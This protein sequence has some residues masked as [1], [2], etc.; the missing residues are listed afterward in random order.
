MVLHGG[1][2]ALREFSSDDW[3]ARHHWT[4]RAEVCRFQPWGPSLDIAVLKPAISVTG[5]QALAAVFNDARR[6]SQS[7][8]G[9]GQRRLQWTTWIAKLHRMRVQGLRGGHEPDKG[10]LDGAAHLHEALQS[11]RL[12]EYLIV[13]REEALERLLGSLL[14]V[15]DCDV[16]QR[17]HGRQGQCGRPE[18]SP[19]AE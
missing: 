11:V 1:R 15:L 14:R 2:I 18:V 19:R 8:L 4:S 3:T 6:Q 9:L 7:I 10:W 12:R 13:G 5:R 16:G 17:V